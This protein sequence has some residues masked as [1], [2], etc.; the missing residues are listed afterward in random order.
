MTMIDLNDVQE[1]ANAMSQDYVQMVPNAW[2]TSLARQR[3]SVCGVRMAE[4]V[5][6]YEAVCNT[7]GA[8]VAFHLEG[9]AADRRAQ[10]QTAAF[11]RCAAA[12]ALT[13]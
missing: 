1:V 12:R 4:A 7:T 3:R 5:G 9:L 11:H 6:V 8:V 13:G 2:A 10:I